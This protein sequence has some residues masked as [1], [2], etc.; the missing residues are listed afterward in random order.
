MIKSSGAASAGDTLGNG[1]GAAVVDVCAKLFKRITKANTKSHFVIF[2]PSKS[3]EKAHG[4]KNADRGYPLQEHDAL[5]A[6]RDPPQ[7]R[8]PD[9]AMFFQ[10]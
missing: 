2:P 10:S 7:S 3:R 8:P 4:Q 6:P 1:G 5:V 9:S